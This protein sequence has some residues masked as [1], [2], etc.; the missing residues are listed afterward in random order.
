M[1][2]RNSLPFKVRGI[3]WIV[4]SLVVLAF[5]TGM[6]PD[7]DH[8]LH[9]LFGWGESGRYLMGYFE[10]AGYILLGSGIIIFISCIC[11]YI[12]LRILKEKT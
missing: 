1:W 7:I 3:A 11:R 12:W 10:I 2:L 4:F 6:L 9:W 8:L 5:I